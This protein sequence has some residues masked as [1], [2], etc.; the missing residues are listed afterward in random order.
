M[1]DSKNPTVHHE[2]TVEDASAG[3]NTKLILSV[4][5]TSLVVFGL[6]AVVAYLI[7]SHDEKQMAAEGMPNP[8]PLLGQ[9]EIGIVDFVEYDGDDR[10][11]TWKAQVAKRLSGY[12]WADRA[13]GRVQL[14]IDVGM[15]KA[16]AEANAGVAVGQANAAVPHEP[17]VPRLTIQQVMANPELIPPPAKATPEAPSGA[18]PVVTPS[19]KP[20]PAPQGGLTQ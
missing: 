1:S 8:T 4:G 19:A 11:P 20:T 6:S 12:S 9:K 5:I 15:R 2:P 13:Q 3:V 10:L 17:S 16:I 18:A 7:L 14:P